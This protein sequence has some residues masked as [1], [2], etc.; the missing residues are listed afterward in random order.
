MTASSCAATSRR[1]RSTSS[2][3]RRLARARDAAQ[4]RAEQ[5]RA[6]GEMGKRT[7]EIKGL[8]EPGAG[9]ARA[10]WRARSAAWSASAARPHGRARADGA[11][12]RRRRRHAAPGDRA[13][14]CPRSSV[15]PRAARGARSSCAT[16][17]RWPAWSRTAT[18]SSRAR[19][20]PTTGALRPDMLVRLPGGKLVVVDSKVPLDAY[21]ARSRPATRTSASATLARHARQTREHIAKLASKGYQRQFDS[22]PEFV[23]MFVPSDG[24]YHAALAAGPRADRV[25][26]RAAGADGD[27]DDADRAAAGRALRL[28]PGA[29]RRVRARDRRVRPRAAPPAGPSSSSRSR[30]SAASS[31]R[32]SAPTTRPSARST[33]A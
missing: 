18:S 15:R 32:R 24:I 25:R 22:T 33:I 17:S 9:E 11:P 6:A 16:S 26:R 3:D 31:T 8:V 20:T 14:S 29:D 1:S 5:E 12:A 27:A 2:E 4:R 21:L 30:R 23:V 28:A 19:S 10:G 13:T 7:E